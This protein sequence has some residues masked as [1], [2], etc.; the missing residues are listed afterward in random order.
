MTAEST[1]CPVVTALAQSLTDSRPGAAE[2]ATIWL[3]LS[4]GLDSS[5]LLHA[6]HSLFTSAQASELEY[7]ICDLRAI[8]VHHG[9]SENADRWAEFCQ[10]LCQ[11][12]NIPLIVERVRVEHSQDSI[13]QAARRARYDAFSRH[14]QNQ[15]LML[16]AHHSDDQVET[17]FQ[18]L[19][20]GSGLRGLGAIRPARPQQLNAEDAESSY[21]LLRPLLQ[22]SRRQL[23]DYAQQHQLRWVEDES[24]QD[25]AY[26][27]NWW[28]QHLL[29]QLWQR[30][31]QRQTAVLRSIEQL[32]RDQLLLDELIEPHLDS[33][34]KTCEWPLTKPWLLDIEQL[35]Q[36]SARMQPY[37]VRAWL[38]KC[39]VISPS[40]IQL[41][42]IF[43]EMLPAAADKQPKLVCG[44][45]VVQR[46]R[47]ALYVYARSCD[48]TTRG[49]YADAE[50]ALLSGKQPAEYHLSGLPGRVCLS[51]ASDTDKCGLKDGHYRLCMASDIPRMTG[52][53]V[54][55][56]IAGRPAK[57][58][59]HIWQEQGIPPWLRALWPCW[60]AESGE[61]A[62]ISGLVIGAD[63]Q[64]Q[65]GT[66]CVW[67]S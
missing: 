39:G 52:G 44:E 46:F 6:L 33:C 49:G 28:R 10:Q 64:D 11:Q 57:K 16:T 18:R 54:Q 43:S 61:L 65:Q 15:D 47:G 27:R 20:R 51:A 63:Y 19:L 41:Q 13:E 66:H 55:I 7:E 29:P 60:L 58:L 34:L 21:Q 2:G 17:F 67:S 40:A 24:N 38:D 36:F 53:V 23:Q 1:Q 45:W 30:Y 50:L 26:D 32:Q 22:V 37:L 4:G 8:H 62:C 12:L 42:R 56:R 59:K 14:L 5:V 9:L 25:Q 3:A 35:R 48:K 31:P